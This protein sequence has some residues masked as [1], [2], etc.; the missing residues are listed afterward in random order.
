ML[1]QLVSGQLSI[2]TFH[3]LNTDSHCILGKFSNTFS[4]ARVISP[5]VGLKNGREYILTSF[6]FQRMNL[7]FTGIG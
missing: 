7:S 3:T 2:H 4:S 6:I 5:I 1:H